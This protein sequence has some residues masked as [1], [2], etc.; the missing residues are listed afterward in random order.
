MFLPKGSVWLTD[1]LSS[2][3]FTLHRC[4]EC[5]RNGTIYPQFQMQ[6]ATGPRNDRQDPNS[7]YFMYDEIYGIDPL[8]LGVFDLFSCRS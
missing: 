6:S 4:D 2:L 1:L 5:V 7:A 3:L 8:L